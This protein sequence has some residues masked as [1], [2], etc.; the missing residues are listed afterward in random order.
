M[1][2]IGLTAGIAKT[3]LKSIPSVFKGAGALIGGKGAGLFYG[4]GAAL[5]GSMRALQFAPLVAGLAAF[6]AWQGVRGVI[7]APYSM[8]SPRV[9]HLGDPSTPG[10]QNP[11]MEFGTHRRSNLDMNATGGLSFALHNRR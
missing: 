6:G 2:L 5:P 10:P 4:A 7:G 9:K 8:D 3:G 11:G 1:G